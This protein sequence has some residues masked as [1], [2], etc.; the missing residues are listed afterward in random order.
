VLVEPS[1]ISTKTPPI[2]IILIY[3][4]YFIIVIGNEK[5]MAAAIERICREKIQ[6]FAQDKHL[7]TSYRV[8][9]KKISKKNAAGIYK[10]NYM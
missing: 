10:V 5:D 6:C 8:E 3:K 7:R 9:A 1:Y 2:P 4:L